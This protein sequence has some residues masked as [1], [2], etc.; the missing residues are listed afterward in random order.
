M[1]GSSRAA[2][3]R[4]A[5]RGDGWLPQTVRRSDMRDQVA[6]L[7]ELRHEL[8][9]GCPI[10]IGALAGVFHVGEP[11]HELPR[12]TVSGSPERI[13]ENLAELIDMGVSHIQMRF[14]NRSL[15]ELCDQIAAFGEQVGPLLSR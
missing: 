9:G 11:D 15:D 7:L 4:A 8:R 13:A 2:L 6:Q 1:G 5:Q 12:G 14:P 10:E 3:R